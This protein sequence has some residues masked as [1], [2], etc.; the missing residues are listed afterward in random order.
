MEVLYLLTW[1]NRYVMLDKVPVAKEQHIK[2]QVQALNDGIRR[3]NL[4]YD[5]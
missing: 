2:V 1:M 5:W 3:D 4:V